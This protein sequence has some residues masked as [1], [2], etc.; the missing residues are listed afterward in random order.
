M[1]IAIYEKIE[2]KVSLEGSLLQIYLVSRFAN[3][4]LDNYLTHKE[5]NGVSE[6]C[7]RYWFRQL[8]TAV[9][10]LHHVFNNDKPLPHSNIKPENILLFKRDDR[11]GNGFDVKLSDC[12]LNV[13]L[14][15]IGRVT[16]KTNPIYYISPPN[17]VIGKK[18]TRFVKNCFAQSLL[19][20]MSGDVYNLGIIVVFMIKGNI[21][22]IVRK[23]PNSTKTMNF[24]GADGI[25]VEFNVEHV[26]E[27]SNGLSPK[28]Y[29]LLKKMLH[30]VSVMRIDIMGVKEHDWLKSFLQN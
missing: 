1:N 5:P 26:R 20:Q 21:E 17:Q 29:D 28:L 15:S 18:Q 25:F 7:A 30:R 13:F 19:Q 27:L 8:S 16:T 10:Y 3:Y 23:P 14:P 22:R 12:G 6:E 4:N 9:H 24:K 11:R 2:Q